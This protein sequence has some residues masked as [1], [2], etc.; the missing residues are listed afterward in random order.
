LWLAS[1]V[2]ALYVVCFF[3]LT[4]LLNIFHFMAS[5]RM[6]NSWDHW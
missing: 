3:Q 4:I 6:K 5:G 2:L 1:V